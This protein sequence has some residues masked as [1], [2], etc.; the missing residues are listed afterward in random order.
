MAVLTSSCFQF[1]FKGG[2]WF[3]CFCL[4]CEVIANAY[5]LVGKAFC[6]EDVLNMGN[7]KICF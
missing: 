1:Y 3:A 5:S 4:T 2:E 6:P 7:M